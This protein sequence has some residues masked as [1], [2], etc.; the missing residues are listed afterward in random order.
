MRF[1]LARSGKTTRGKKEKR[2]TQ[3][4]ESFSLAFSLSLSVCV[5]AY[6]H[7][8]TP[9]TDGQ[10]QQQPPGPPV[11]YTKEPYLF[12]LQR[13]KDHFLSSSSGTSG[14]PIFPHVLTVLCFRGNLPRGMPTRLQ[15]IFVLN[16]VLRLNRDSLP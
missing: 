13:N 16:S 5:C 3:A 11:S 9:T 6:G 15:W 2:C 8:A 7:I 12:P 14:K 4:T 10:Q 1:V